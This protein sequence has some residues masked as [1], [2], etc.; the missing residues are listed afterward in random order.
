MKAIRSPSSISRQTTC[1]SSIQFRYFVSGPTR[2]CVVLSSLRGNI[3]RRRYVFEKYN[4]STER[5]REFENLNLIGSDVIRTKLE[6][7]FAIN[8]I[9]IEHT[10]GTLC[11]PRNEGIDV[12]PIEWNNWH[13]DVD[14]PII[15][16]VSWPKEFIENEY[17]G[18]YTLATSRSI[19]Y[20]FPLL[21]D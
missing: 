2:N 1:F 4:V 11:T 8:W 6:E 18:T 16:F 20:C 7:K 9:F 12:I 19:V 21:P 13:D 15:M 3:Y 17:W 10:S 14:Q 5:E